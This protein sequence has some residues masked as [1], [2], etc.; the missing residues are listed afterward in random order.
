MA[1]QISKLKR[2][3]LGISI[4]LI[5]ALFI[6]YGINTFHKPPKYEDFCE[7][8]FP[9]PR[10]IEKEDIAKCDAVQ[11]ANDAFED[12]CYRQDGI[13]R[14]E[15]DEDGCQVA[16]ECDMCSKEYR[17]VREKY[18]RDVFI[19]SVV[20]GLIFVILGGV[21]LKLESVSAGIMGGG[22]L[23]IIYGTLRYWGD[24]GDV[25]RFIILGVVLVVL[26]W[27]GYRKFKK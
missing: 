14:Y 11:T 3:I 2:T 10:R 25:L 19:I 5:L 20:A 16:K 8:K 26:I 18:N 7:E 4:A 17:D 22:V 13:V 23:S 6:G 9:E 15:A 1:F 21:V 24:M 27:I 12:S